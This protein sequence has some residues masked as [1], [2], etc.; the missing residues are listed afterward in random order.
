MTK[1]YDGYSVGV[2]FIFIFFKPYFTSI[3]EKGPLSNTHCNP[4]FA[5]TIIN[6]RLIPHAYVNQTQYCLQFR[7]SNNAI[8]SSW[9]ILQQLL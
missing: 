8:F 1:Y 7:G 9:V 3:G 6:K 4:L 2:Y 5:A